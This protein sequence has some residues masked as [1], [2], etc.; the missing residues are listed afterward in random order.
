MLGGVAS[1]RKEIWF[2]VFCNAEEDVVSKDSSQARGQA[3]RR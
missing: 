1:I 2:I 3:H